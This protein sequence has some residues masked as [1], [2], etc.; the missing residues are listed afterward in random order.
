MDPN[1]ALDDTANPLNQ[2]PFILAFRSYGWI[3]GYHHI[4]LCPI[5]SLSPTKCLFSITVSVM[6]YHLVSVYLIHIIYMVVYHVC[7][8]IYIHHIII[9]HTWSYLHTIIRLWYHCALFT[10]PWYCGWFRNPA[11]VDRWFI[12]LFIGFQ[13]FQPSKVV[14]DFTTIHSITMVSLWFYYGFT[15]V[16]ISTYI[17]S[18]YEVPSGKLT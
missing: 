10:N 11:P 18:I 1:T 17:N 4:S 8:Y 9:H 5:I 3:I 12:P 6:S 13:L 14:Q 7:I 2:R 15:M 16:V